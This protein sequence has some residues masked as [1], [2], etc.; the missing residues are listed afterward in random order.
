MKILKIKIG[1]SHDHHFTVGIPLLVRRHLYIESAHWCMAMPYMATIFYWC[2]HALY[3][4][5][6][7]I[8]DIWSLSSKH[9][10]ELPNLWYVNVFWSPLEK[11]IRNRSLFASAISFIEMEKGISVVC[12]IFD[13]HHRHGMQ[14]ICSVQYLPFSPLTITAVIKVNPRTSVKGNNL[15]VTMRK[16]PDHLSDSSRSNSLLITELVYMFVIVY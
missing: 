15:M 2:G 14:P 11:T 12:G 16:L 1:R 6:T 13:S 5:R 4:A 9:N 3:L 7:Q 8:C 10:R